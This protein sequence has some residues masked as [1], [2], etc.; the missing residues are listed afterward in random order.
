MQEV[1]ASIIKDVL[2]VIDSL[3][4]SKLL[5]KEVKAA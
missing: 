5:A 1:T 4:D 2:H 3:G